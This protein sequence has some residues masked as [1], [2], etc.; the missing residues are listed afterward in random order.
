MDRPMP[1]FAFSMM[2]AMFKVRDFLFPPRDL[3]EEAGLAPG[4][5]VL[6]YGCGPGGYV[7]DAADMVGE[8]GKVYALDIHPLAIQQVQKIAEKRQLTNVETIHSDC[9][10]R[11]PD[12]SLDVV[13]LYD[14]FHMLNRRSSILA[15]LHRVL[16]EDGV[17]SFS[18]PHMSKDDAV[19]RVTGNQLFRLS[20]EGRKTLSFSKA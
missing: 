11:L 5:Q 12:A 20:S 17:L 19:S 9:D 15:E 13:L 8:E 16:K 18:D 7:V 14:V 1:K 3:L 6:D 4:F 10:T 2:S